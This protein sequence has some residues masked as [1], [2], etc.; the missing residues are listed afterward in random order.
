MKFDRFL[1]QVIVL[2]VEFDPTGHCMVSPHN[3]AWLCKALKNQLN[4]RAEGYTAKV[5]G[6]LVALER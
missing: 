5:L 6:A 2:H 1:V 3:G 4:D